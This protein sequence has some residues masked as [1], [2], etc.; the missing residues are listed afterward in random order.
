MRQSLQPHQA[1]TSRIGIK[2]SD[3]IAVD[4]MPPNT[5]VEKAVKESGLPQSEYSFYLMG[6]MV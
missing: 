5:I 4:L 6:T 2:E 1:S 3:G